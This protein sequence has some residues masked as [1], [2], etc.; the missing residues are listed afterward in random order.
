MAELTKI[1]DGVSD[2]ASVNYGK[3]M[4][5]KEI[6]SLTSNP[7]A[8]DASSK[9]PIS[10]GATIVSETLFNEYAI[11]NAGISVWEAIF[12][13]EFFLFNQSSDNSQ[14]TM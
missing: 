4:T 7:N 13:T 1:L 9:Y 5:K 11:A 14:K 3:L 8:R 12:N 2:P 6:A 10:N